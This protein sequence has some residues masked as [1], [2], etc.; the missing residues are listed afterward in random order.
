MILLFFISP[1]IVSDQKECLTFRPTFVKV[2]KKHDF[3]QWLIRWLCSFSLQSKFHSSTAP[4]KPTYTSARTWLRTR[5]CCGGWKWKCQSLSH[6]RFFATPWTVTCQALLSMRFSR[7]QYWSGFP[8]PSPGD[9]PN[10]G[11]RLSLPSEPPGNPTFKDNQSLEGNR[12]NQ[13]FGNEIFFHAN[14]I[15]SN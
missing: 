9:L 7:Q 4:L 3:S 8:F 12:L 5:R 13:E 10:P 11:I 15:L 2:M 6:V 14:F 1:C